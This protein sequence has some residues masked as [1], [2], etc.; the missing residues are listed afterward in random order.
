MLNR[1]H[2]SN[3]ERKDY[4][5][6]WYSDYFIAGK[7]VRKNVSAKS[8]IIHCYPVVFYLY[9]RHKTVFFDVSSLGSATP[10]RSLEKIKQTIKQKKVDYI[11]S[12]KE[13]E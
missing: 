11:V 10:L 2:L 4:Y 8:V 1:K 5:N 12:K 9:S 3:I 13:S 7:W 6:S